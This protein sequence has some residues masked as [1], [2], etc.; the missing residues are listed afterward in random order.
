MADR[1]AIARWLARVSPEV[2]EVYQAATALYDD[3]A[4]PAR[5]LLV[6][7][8]VRE[9]RNRLLAELVDSSA[10]PRVQY[11]D[12][13]ES[14][15]Q[16]LESWPSLEFGQDVMTIP[17]ETWSQV[18][19]LVTEHRDASEWS[20]SGRIQSVLRAVSFDGSEPPGHVYGTWSE[21]FDWVERHMHVGLSGPPPV[22]WLE[23]H[24]PRFEKM[25]GVLASR[26]SVG[27]DRI[28]EIASSQLDP[29]LVDEVLRLTLRPELRAHACRT[30]PGGEW[31]GALRDRSFFSTPP[32]VVEQDGARSF[33]LWQEGYYLLRHAQ[34]N[35][36]EVLEALLSVQYSKNT[37]VLQT[38]LACSLQLTDE[39]LLSFTPELDGWLTSADSLDSVSEEAEELFLRL[40]ELDSEASL[41]VFEQVVR[42]RQAEVSKIDDQRRFQVSRGPFARLHDYHYESVVSRLVSA[43]SGNKLGM[44]SALRILLQ[45]AER[46]CHEPSY[47]PNELRTQETSVHVRP[48]IGDHAQNRSTDLSNDVIVLLR[49]LALACDDIGASAEVLGEHLRIRKSVIGRRIY[50][51]VL[52]VRQVPSGKIVEALAQRSTLEDFRYRRE[53]AELMRAK[54]SSIPEAERAVV[55]EVIDEYLN[56]LEGSSE[57]VGRRRRDWY[58]YARDGLDGSRSRVLQSLV[59]QFGQPDHPEFMFWSATD[60]VPTPTLNESDNY[61]LME[62]A[63]V[64]VRISFR[65]TD[66]SLSMVDDTSASSA[67][68]ARATEFAELAGNLVDAE[69]ATIAIF[70]EGLRYSEAH[71]GAE[72]WAGVRDLCVWTASQ[73]DSQGPRQEWSWSRTRIAAARLILDSVQHRRVSEDEAEAVGS[74]IV[75]LLAASS[76]RDLD[77]FDDRSGEAAALNSPGGLACHIAMLEIVRGHSADAVL[78]RKIAEQL[79]DEALRPTRSDLRANAAAVAQYLDRLAYYDDDLLLSILQRIFEPEENWSAEAWRVFL[80]NVTASKELFFSLQPFYQEALDCLPHADAEEDQELLRHVWRLYVT[81]VIDLDTTVSAF[82]A[83]DVSTSEALLRSI[84]WHLGRLETIDARLVARLEDF[85]DFVFDNLETLSGNGRRFFGVSF[86]RWF[87]STLLTPDVA[88]ALLDTYLTHIGPPQEERGVALRLADIASSSS[89]L[90]AHCARCMA[91]MS[92]PPKA[93]RYPRSWESSAQTVVQLAA[94]HSNQ[95]GLQGDVEAIAD[96]QLAAGAMNFRVPARPEEQA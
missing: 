92:R 6:S 87:G 30:L 61:E 43:L 59:E 34:V 85:W 55:M 72:A 93:A 77:W 79:L 50:L 2:E 76:D 73:V 78:D 75:A 65:A 68:A 53:V 3:K 81:E 27:F 58:S 91:K 4:A 80:R 89:G 12:R 64:L 56:S 69:P 45:Q 84:G 24:F 29:L 62:P 11:F 35:S 83:A 44:L 82:A 71:L 48:S 13:T 41:R 8:A 28:E 57:S 22:D 88:L 33:P 42:V 74:A 70:L 39:D 5:V 9:I 37:S 21:S 32:D 95:L 66:G 94:D 7:H 16:S 86:D 49:D 10:P 1:T 47:D 54:F 19:A 40:V 14:I 38:V 63:E 20:R 90:I 26:T 18:Q 36:A 52:A 25:L 67:I 17:A 46:C 60:W 51:H 15:A 31:I 23:T 96:F